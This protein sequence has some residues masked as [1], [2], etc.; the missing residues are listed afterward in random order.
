M[1]T[2]TVPLINDSSVTDTN[3]ILSEGSDMKRQQLANYSTPPLPSIREDRCSCTLIVNG[4]HQMKNTV[5]A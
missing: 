3:V 4:Q 5:H 1:C 2:C